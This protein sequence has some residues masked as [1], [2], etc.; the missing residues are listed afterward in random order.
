VKRWIWITIVAVVGIA[1][2]AVGVLVHKLTIEVPNYPPVGRTVW[3]SQN[4]TRE[5]REWF[6]HADQGTQTFR[7]PYEWF[8]ALE[9][10]V[11]SLATQGLLSDTIYLDR[12][13]FIPDDGT[14]ARAEL[15]VGFAHG[16]QMRRDDG[17][18]WT[19]PRSNQPWSRVGLTCAACHTGR[20][21][22]NGTTVLI[23]GAPA[24]ANIFKF[25]SA[26]G[27]SLYLT[28]HVPFRF[29]RFADRVL[30]PDASGD[31]RAALR[32]QLDQVIAKY[33]EARKLEEAAN[34]SG[35]EEGFARLDALNRIGNAVF[36]IDLGR[37][38]NYA[39]PAAP[40]HFPRIW[41]A[42]WFSWVQYNGSIE[43]PM[44]RNAGEAL[45][46][47]AWLNM[48]GGSTPLFS[49]SAQLKTVAEI[50]GLLAGQQPDAEHGFTGLQSPKW[51]DDILP[52]VDPALAA[53][54]EVL[55]KQICQACHLPAVTTPEF[56]TSK[57][58]LPPNA[59]GQRYLDV[60]LID[61]THIG[62]DPEQAEGMSKRRVAVP[63]SLG[64]GTNEFGPALG[65]LVELTV[66][67]WYDDQQPPVPADLRDAMNGH[68]A[69]GIQAPLKYK[70][71]P[72]NGVWATPPYLHNGSVPTL[73]ALLSP[74][75]ER[76]KVFYLGDREYDPKNVGYRGS[77]M[78]GGFTFDTSLPGNSNAGHEFTDV[79]GRKGAIGRKLSPEERYAIIEYLKTQ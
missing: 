74:V 46:V 11:P 47:I 38:E 75:D 10:P 45:G 28:Q 78:E 33:D 51:P 58:W 69:N 24:L 65:R 13:G 62:T 14:A 70:V 68:R 40:V 16:G 29:G 9:Q 77:Q 53:K 43:Q 31:E 59:A 72:L 73:Y 57:R 56:W 32:A 25:Q 79:A 27:V 34:P 2:V 21:T 41:N 18:V 30:G 26:V 3:L 5:Q 50:E 55:Y 39:A 7:V 37:P 67:R 35:F 63:D 54:G 15:P 12:Y 76:P 48:T 52:K 61:I 20:F 17:S 36:A 42:S 4:W 19:N 6:H 71:R 60:E 44:V 49:S 23:D 66:N 1:S 22:V 64:L 8:V